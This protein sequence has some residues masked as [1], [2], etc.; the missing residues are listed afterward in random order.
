M[1]NSKGHI[2]AKHA[3]N[4]LPKTSLKSLFLCLSCC[5]EVVLV[6]W[7][8]GAQADSIYHSFGNGIWACHEPEPKHSGHQL[9]PKPRV[10]LISW[11]WKYIPVVIVI[12]RTVQR[13]I[14]LQ[15]VNS[16]I[17]PRDSFSYESLPPSWF[18]KISAVLGRLKCPEFLAMLCMRWLRT[19]SSRCLWDL[20]SV[21]TVANL[22][23]SLFRQWCSSQ[24]FDNSI[25]V[26]NKRNKRWRIKKVRRAAKDSLPCSRE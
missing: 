24:H 4:S 10:F 14:T 3:P 19:T 22:W 2:S 15:C 12:V 1:Q 7:F 13:I 6:R 17:P 16:N 20:H 26:D 21:K 11:G 9:I 23:S 18:R 5:V 25:I 8:F